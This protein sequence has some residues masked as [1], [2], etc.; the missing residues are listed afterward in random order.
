[1]KDDRNKSFCLSST[2]L[3]KVEL[4][5]VIGQRVPV[6][7]SVAIANNGVF[8]CVSSFAVADKPFD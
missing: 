3:C 8:V 2:W 6:N 5:R 1:M 4:L 7:G